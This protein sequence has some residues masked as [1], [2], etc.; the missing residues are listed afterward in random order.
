MASEHQQNRRA[1]QYI[2]RL[3]AARYSSTFCGGRI[4]N[5]PKFIC[6][7]NPK[8]VINSSGVATRRA[9]VNITWPAIPFVDMALRETGAR[10][11]GGFTSVC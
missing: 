8:R 1:T 4:I 7:S 11:G 9:F 2:K 5:F 3:V 10:G 6:L